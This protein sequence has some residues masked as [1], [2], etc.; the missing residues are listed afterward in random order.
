MKSGTNLTRSIRNT[1]KLLINLY[2]VVMAG[3]PYFHLRKELHEC[4][5]ELSLSVVGKEHVIFS[6]LLYRAKSQHRREK[7]FQK[8]VRVSIAHVVVTSCISSQASKDIK[9]YL[10][11]TPDEQVQNIIKLLS[12]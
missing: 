5:P 9:K 2:D 7:S 4:V 1:I 3:V 12:R 8:L 10:M 6:R 11:H